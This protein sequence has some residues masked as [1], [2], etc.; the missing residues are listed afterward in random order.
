MDTPIP[1]Y[2]IRVSLRKGAFA[3]RKLPIPVC[4]PSRAFTATKFEPPLPLPSFLLDDQS[5]GRME[6][7]TRAPESHN[8]TSIAVKRKA[9]SSEELQVRVP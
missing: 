7:A 5:V 4:H 1:E 8:S 3:T 9:D 2:I 6:E